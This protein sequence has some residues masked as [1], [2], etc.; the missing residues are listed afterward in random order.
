MSELK[1]DEIVFTKVNTAELL[2]VGEF[3]TDRLA[4]SDVVVQTEYST[5]SAGTERANISGDKNVSGDGN[6]QA[7]PRYL[8]YSSCGT[9]IATGSEVKTVQVGDRVAVF[10]GFHKNYNIVP[11]SH[12]VKIPD[13]VDMQ[14]AAFAFIATFPLAAIRK[15][16]LEIGESCMVMGLGPLGQIA[17]KLARLGGAYPVIAVDPNGER[18]AVALQNGADFAFDPTEQDFAEKVKKLT[19]GGVKT[20]VEVTGI[21]AGLNETLDCMAKF[22]RVALL[23]CTRDSNFTVDY[24]K[25]VHFPGITLVGAHT[26]ARPDAE[27][28]PNYWT[29]QDDIKSVLNLCLGGRLDLKKLVTEVHAPSDC[30]DVYLRLVFDKNFPIGVQFKWR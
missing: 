22:G 30:P 13:G 17:V 23:G 28:S 3:D 26:L 20:A 16:K 11:E 10:W 2:C 14:D 7:F 29:H 21:G 19:G 4:K 25:K 6:S 1:I 15:V 12:V 5:V 8:G 24:Y 27:S 18:R 9:V